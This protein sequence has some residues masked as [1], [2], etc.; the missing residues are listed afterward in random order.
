VLDEAAMM[1]GV[2]GITLVRG[3]ISGDVNNTA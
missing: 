1:P 2:K 3:F